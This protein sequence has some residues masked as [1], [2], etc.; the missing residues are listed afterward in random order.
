MQTVDII[1]LLCFVPA[2]VQGIRKG[3]IHQAAGLLSVIL[4]IWMS[5]RFSGPVCTWLQP[6]LSVSEQVLHVI[7]FVLILVLVVIVLSLIAKLL[8]SLVK[9]VMMGWLDKLLGL[10]FSLLK[11][12][13]VIGLLLMLFNTLN[14]RLHLV[15]EEVLEQSVLYGPLKEAAYTVFPFLKDLLFKPS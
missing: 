11:A 13:L 14:L 6:Y 7:A 2:I 8:E 15:S 1:L 9:T 5:F 12:G 10:V 4:G 3:F